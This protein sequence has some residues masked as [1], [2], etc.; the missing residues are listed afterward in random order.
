MALAVIG[1]A[2]AVTQLIGQATG[3]IAKIIRA[4]ETARQNRVECDHLVCRVSSVHGVVYN[5]PPYQEMAPPLK[6]VNHTLEEAHRMVIACRNR[7]AASQFFGS[8]RIA[9]CFSQINLRIAA[10]VVILNLSLCSCMARR[11][12]NQVLHPVPN[13]IGVPTSTIAMAPGFSS[14][15]L[16]TQMVVSQSPS[17]VSSV[18]FDNPRAL[19]GS[20]I[21]AAT[22][23]AV[24]LGRGSSGR[25]YMGRLQFQHHG[26]VTVA[27][28]AVKVLE[29][30]GRHG[31][32]DAFV[33]ESN[34]LSGLRH[35]HIVRLVGW[36]AEQEYRMLVYEH[37]GKGTL[38]DQLQQLGGCSSASPVTRS[39]DW[40]TR[41]E[42]LL[43]VARAIHYMHRGADPVV[44]HRNVSSSN[45]LLDA[46]WTL[47]LSGFGSAVFQAAGEDEEHGAGGQ[48]VEEVVG[49]RG[50]ID[51]EYNLTNRVNPASD[52][53]SF[54]VVMLEA[55][56][57]RPPDVYG[58]TL[59]LLVDSALP[60]I[61]MG[62]LREV[63]DGRPSPQ[64]TRRQLDALDLVAHTASHC[65]WPGRQNR[66]PISHVVANLQTALQM[67]RS[68][69][70]VSWARID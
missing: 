55:L 25:V 19:T 47:R 30:H 15:S 21:A 8:R 37:M 46:N 6:V 65:L 36:C 39:W 48:L 70:P 63:L 13:D 66:L 61:R 51:P 7:G 38:R 49:T 22:S 29:K 44:I 23:F 64:P 59:G 14:G 35:D 45:I 24:E 28:V 50:Y 42:M 33:A 1:D 12:S 52:V 60:I 34:I 53:Y 20:E 32:E 54:G 68:N 41:V 2:A 16:Q 69:E 17:Q 10:D 26:T 5:L 58:V 4:V 56:T 43:A 18:S 11:H 31:V 40:E 62:N 67:I 57:G 27:E 9:D 3:L